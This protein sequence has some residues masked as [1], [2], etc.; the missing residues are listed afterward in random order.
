ME[1]RITSATGFSPPIDFEGIIAISLPMRAVIR[2][3]ASIGN[4]GEGTWSGDE[5][6]RG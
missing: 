4:P 1:K 2:R 3:I 5:N 6:I